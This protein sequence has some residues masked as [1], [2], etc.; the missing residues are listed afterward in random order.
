MKC[1]L[2]YI[3]L[4]KSIIQYLPVAHACTLGSTKTWRLRSMEIT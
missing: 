3:Q 1:E 2:M 4:A